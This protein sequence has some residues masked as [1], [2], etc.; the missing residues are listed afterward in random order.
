M[1]SISKNYKQSKDANQEHNA[2]TVK[3]EDNVKFVPEIIQQHFMNL[4]KGY[5]ERQ[6]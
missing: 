5:K 2:K 6:K 1:N 4:T 3:K